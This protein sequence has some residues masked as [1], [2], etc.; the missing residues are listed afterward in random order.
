M[1]DDRIGFIERLGRLAGQTTYRVPVE[2]I[3]TKF[4]NSKKLFGFF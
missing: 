1:S 4:G 3:G 2:G